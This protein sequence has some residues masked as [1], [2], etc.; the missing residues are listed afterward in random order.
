MSSLCKVRSV[1]AHL[2]FYQLVVPNAKSEQDIDSVKSLEIDDF[3][4]R[5]NEFYRKVVGMLTRIK[6]VGTVLTTALKERENQRKLEYE[7]LEAKL[8]A[9]LDAKV[10]F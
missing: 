3:I 5:L 10:S 7:E 1:K 4:S 8:Q 9:A 2:I 6:S